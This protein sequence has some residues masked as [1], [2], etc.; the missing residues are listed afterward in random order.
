MESLQ[1]PQSCGCS[2]CALSR[3]C[4]P[5]PLRCPRAKCMP[6]AWQDPSPVVLLG[7]LTALSTEATQGEWAQPRLQQQGDVED[8]GGELAWSGALQ[9]CSC[10]SHQPAFTTTWHRGRRR[11]DRDVVTGLTKSRS[12]FR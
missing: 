12:P 8:A 3:A 2:M 5:F 6:E 10:F 7:L 9:S 4:E 11:Q 1:Y